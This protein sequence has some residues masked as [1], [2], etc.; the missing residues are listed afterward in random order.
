MLWFMG[1]CHNEHV[2]KKEKHYIMIIILYYI[3]YVTS[4][5]DLCIINL[6]DPKNIL[7]HCVSKK[8]LLFYLI[9][10]FF[11]EHFIFLQI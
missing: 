5:K 4:D 7:D 2:T 3:M 1:K 10:L 6:C 11:K 8:H 9:V